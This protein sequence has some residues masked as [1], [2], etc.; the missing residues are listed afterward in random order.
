MEYDVFISYS[1]SDVKHIDKFVERLEEMGFRVWIDRKGIESGDSFKRVIVN[2]IENSAVFVF[3]NSV[4]SSKSP[5]TTKELGVAI[6]L[7]K[8]IIPVKIDKAPYS[9]EVF[10]DLINLDYVDYSDLVTRETMM[11]KFVNVVISKL[12][13]RWEEIMA[14]RK[15]Q[16]KDAY[17]EEQEIAKRRRRRK[18][19]LICLLLPIIGIN[20]A[21]ISFKNKKK[22]KGAKQLLFSSLG[23]LLLVIAIV[24]L[25]TFKPFTSLP[26]MVTNDR[27][28]DE[29]TFSIR[30]IPLEMKH[31]D[32]GTFLMGS[33]DDVADG[34]EGPVHQVTLGSYYIGETEVTVSLWKAVM[35][36]KRVWGKKR[37]LPYE[38]EEDVS[39]VHDF[40]SRLNRLTGLTFR[41]PTE[42]EWEYAAR[43]GKKSKGFK[44]AGSNSVYDV[45]WFKENGLKRPHKVKEMLRNELGLY[46]MSGNLWELCGDLYG[47]YDPD[48]KPEINPVG[49][50]QGAES[51]M[52]GGSY[53]NREYFCRVSY[54]NSVETEN[55]NGY[56]LGFRLVLGDD[57]GVTTLKTASNAKKPSKSFVN[58]LTIEDVGVP[59]KMIF[60][61]G[62]TFD[63]GGESDAEDALPVH[64]VTLDSY[65]IGETEVTQALWE[66]VMG[67]TLEEMRDKG[68]PEG[69]FKGVGDDYP[70]YYLN[71]YD[72]QD[73][74]RRLSDLTGRHFQLPTEAQW[75]FA[76]RGG[77][78]RGYKYAGG[79]K[80]DDVAWYQ[81]NSGGTSHPVKQKAANSLGL[82]D[83]NGNV[84]EWCNDWYGD[85]VD[86]DQVNPTGPAT[87]DFHVLRGASWSSIPERVGVADRNNHHTDYRHSRFGLRVVMTIDDSED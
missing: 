16:N 83:M 64:K 20:L 57:R 19:I 51:V 32:G 48:A 37:N 26:S 80:L 13:E 5:W 73:F 53:R 27:T 18:E 72:C 21:Y 3:F 78:T 85:Y 67:T 35:E 49:P 15:A 55:D 33:E 42:A 65:Y 62:A 24:L 61:E 10:F 76:A 34:D 74:V 39:Q 4:S 36:K 66:A 79:N 29:W 25:L 23:F 86:Y 11:D 6:N 54:R 56:P 77:R 9:K 69:E 68:D 50:Q 44:Y 2:A 38:L 8:P 17:D 31:V 81:D 41:L 75:E 28:D 84:W 40:I 46:D 22:E 70:M 14:E 43:G 52:R 87:G 82:Y 30:G 60:V 12:P 59:F 63:M 45:A 7:G 1:R 58:E 47:P 71:W